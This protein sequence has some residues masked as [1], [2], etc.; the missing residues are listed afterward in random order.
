MLQRIVIAFFAFFLTSRFFSEVLGILPKWVDV[1]DLPFIV[2]LGVAGLLRYAHPDVD[3]STHRH[4]ARAIFAVT[5]IT[6]A[7]AFINSQDLLAPAAVLFAIGFLQG[8]ILFVA[9]N[10]IV[11]DV[12]D[13]AQ[14]VRKLFWVLLVINIA[15]VVFINIPHFIATRN[16]DVVSGTYGLNAYQFSILLVICAGLLLG[17]EEFHKRGRLRLIV[18]QTA[19]LVIFYLLQYRA[20][21]PIFLLAIVMMI[22]AL[23]GKPVV[24][25]LIAG[26]FIVAFSAGTISYI[27]MQT[28][29]ETKLK[30]S[31]WEKI[32]A[33][34]TAFLQYGKFQAYPQTLKLF[35]DQPMAAVAGVGPGNYVS[36]AYYTFS[37]EIATSK[38]KGVGAMV[39]KLFGLS[40]ARF[41]KVSE[42]YVGHFRSQAVLGSYQLSNPHSSFLA[43]VAEIGVFGGMI[44]IG[45]YLFM[46]I[47]SFRLLQQAKEIAPE[48]LPL[49]TALVAGSVYLFGLAFLDNYWEMSRATLPVWLLFWG[50][51]AGVQVKRNALQSGE[52]AALSALPTI[53][54]N[55]ESL[56]EM[57][58]RW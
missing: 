12:D 17:E 19:V 45:I 33:N 18:G 36:R 50:T 43:P 54:A 47:K 35:D 15:V 6:M 32:L 26:G 34:P 38:S 31:D 7:S 14:R 49:A 22:A 37:Y 4:L 13:M 3:L 5:L 40:G 53:A 24:K 8:P 23:Y 55:A 27:L 46:M 29:E 16:P 48:F 20:A 9:L 57:G 41:T 21:V 1:L 30:Y 11:E 56:K 39:E 28:Q 58:G 42:T 44:I 2:F 25:V 52:P 51:S 10:K